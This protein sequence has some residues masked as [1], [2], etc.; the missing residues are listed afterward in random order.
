MIVIKGHSGCSVEVMNDKKPFIRKK[1]F[2]KDYIQRLEKQAFKQDNFISEEGM[3][4]APKILNRVKTND[5]YYFDMEYFYSL[6]TFTFL[7]ISDKCTIDSF[8]T[9][10]FKLIDY[11]TKQ[12]RIIKIEKCVL[13]S[14]LS[15]IESSLN[16]NLSELNIFYKEYISNMKE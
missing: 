11:N 5:T 13:I 10:C 8:L 3:I 9:N 14:K 2:N 6:D 1:T 7:E 12:S 4:I 15:S 16:L